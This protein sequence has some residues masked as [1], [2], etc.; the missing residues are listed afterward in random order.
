M[1]EPRFDEQQ[2][3]DVKKKVDIRKVSNIWKKNPNIR[4]LAQAD[5]VAFL[6]FLQ[7]LKI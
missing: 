1:L 2:A 7:R 3:P 5:F 6:L 4:E